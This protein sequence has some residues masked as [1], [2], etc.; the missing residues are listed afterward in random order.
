[1]SNYPLP[2]TT[3]P[4]TAAP[5]TSELLPIQEI[6]AANA[7]YQGLPPAPVYRQEHGGCRGCLWLVGGM[8]GCLVIVV[9][10]ALLPVIFG[11]TTLNALIGGL[12]GTFR[13]EPPT[14]SIAS[15]QTI[16]T[17]I[18]PLGQLVSISAQ[19]AKA[20]VNVGI[21]Q[22]ALNA[23]GFS[24]SHVV[25]GAVEA[26]IDLTRI[27]ETDI[28]Y[29]AVRDIYRLTVPAPQLTSCR[30]DYIRQYDRSFTTCN[31]DW[32]EAR[33]L[34]NYVT[35]IDFRDT[36]IEGGILNRAEGETRLVLGN[37]IRLLTGKDAEIVFQQPGIPDAAAT[38]S[39]EGTNAVSTAPLYPASCSPEV[40]QGWF[41]NNAIG[42]WQR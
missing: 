31:V 26:G 25:Q 37:F 23:C 28:T 36:S 7:D 42:N 1:M 39:V 33:L 21:G 20:D 22:G 17:G 18:Q 19:L 14:A 5:P 13:G 34:A 8:G 2:P 10:I 38:A 27:D 15:T 24:A 16:I 6:V 9:V 32:D 30:V 35:L 11:V 29:D 12:V 40:P 4:E 3:L 41:F